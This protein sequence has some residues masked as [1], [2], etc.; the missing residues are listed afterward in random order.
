MNKKI[1]ICLLT[2]IALV[3]LKDLVIYLSFKANQSYI[4][5]NLCI[6]RVNEISMCYGSCVLEKVMSESKEQESENPMTFQEDRQNFQLLVPHSALI[7]DKLLNKTTRNFKQKYWLHEA[8]LKEI[9][10]PPQV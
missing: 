5:E 6:N 3:V 8:H 9:F 10:H 1:T 2:L 7:K 4:A